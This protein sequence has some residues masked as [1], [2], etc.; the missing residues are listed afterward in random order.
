MHRR[1]AAA[2][3]A[4][5]A[6][7]P[8]AVARPACPDPAIFWSRTFVIGTAAQFEGIAAASDGGAI[9]VGSVTL[10]TPDWFVH[11]YVAAG[12]VVWSRTLDPG[13]GADQA[14]D[15]VRDAAG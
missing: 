5:A 6:C 13:G 11:R 15:A 14:W 4:L 3:L 1:L 10:T 2:G 12:N 8:A 7:L 9:A